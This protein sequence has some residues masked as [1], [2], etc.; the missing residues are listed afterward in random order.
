MKGTEPKALGFTKNERSGSVGNATKHKNRFKDC[1]RFV[2]EV[3]ST[4]ESIIMITQSLSLDKDYLRS[5]ISE[6]L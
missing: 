3:L 6:E 2:C 1:F 5:D 4:L